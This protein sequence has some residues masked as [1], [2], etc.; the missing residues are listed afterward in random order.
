MHTLRH[1][2][3]S[4]AWSS[5]VDIWVLQSILGHASSDTT[6]RYVAI[7]QTAE[8]AAIESMSASSVVAATAAASPDGGGATFVSPYYHDSVTVHCP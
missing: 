8:R 5:G 3:A 2:F 7:P 6:R 1:R 4:R